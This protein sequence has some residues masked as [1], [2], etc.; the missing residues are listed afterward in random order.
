MV[1]PEKWTLRG[2][3]GWV[4]SGGDLRVVLCLFQLGVLFFV[5]EKGGGKYSPNSLANLFKLE[6]LLITGVWMI[7]SNMFTFTWRKWKDTPVAEWRISLEAPNFPHRKISISCETWGTGEMRACKAVRLDQG[8]EQLKDG[9]G[10]VDYRWWVIGNL[11]EFGT[12]LSVFWQFSRTRTW[13]AHIYGW[14]RHTAWIE[15]V[16]T[17]LLYL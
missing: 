2:I 6:K 13:Y 14:S 1:R 9:R 17:L 5:S 10:C 7:A 8:S 12:C 3:F 16:W 15:H 11:D 4:F